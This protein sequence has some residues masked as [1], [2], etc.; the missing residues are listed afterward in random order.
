[1]TLHAAF[2]VIDHIAIYSML[3]LAISLLMAYPRHKATWVALLIGVSTAAY[4]IFSRVLFSGW[5]PEPYR[6]V[7]IAPLMASTQVLMNTV[8]GAFMVLAFLLFEDSGRKFP[9]WLAAL[10][11]A[12]LSLEDLVPFLFGITTRPSIEAPMTD[13]SDLL[14]LTFELVPAILQTLFVGLALYWTLKDWQADLINPR[15]RIRL[16]LLVLIAVNLVSYTLLTRLVLDPNDITLF[17]V[18]ETYQALNA[19]MNSTVMVYLLITQGSESL[20]TPTETRQ[21]TPSG[22]PDVAL[23]EA[24]MKAGIHRQTGLTIASLAAHIKVPEYRLRKLINARLG[25]RNFNQ[26]LNHYRIEEV[27]TALADPAQ[28]HLPI[29]TLALSV[30]YQS[31]NPFNRAFRELKGTTPS[32]FR[33][34]SLAQPVGADIPEGP[35]A[36]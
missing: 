4:V 32:A 16:F 15:R 13:G 5:I 33:Q 27:A 6:F 20:A 17:Y 19:L 14:Y 12:Q 3:V 11:A 10:L 36:A 28:R 30:G 22:D 26:M 9:R 31:I 2:F 34:A 21:P 8:P 23:F 29:L 35:P 7:D 25:F 1:L 18:H 24:A